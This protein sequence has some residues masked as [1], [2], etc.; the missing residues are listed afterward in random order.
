MLL[1]IKEKG[2]C[3]AFPSIKRKEK[4]KMNELSELAKIIDN[5]L[6]TL[7]SDEIITV[8]FLPA[9]N[10]YVLKTLKDYMYTPKIFET[11]PFTSSFTY[12]DI[13]RNLDSFFERLKMY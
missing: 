3:K 4:T 6:T 1:W 9:E 13:L 10:I 8:V 12:T 7:K 11:E 5:K 2:T